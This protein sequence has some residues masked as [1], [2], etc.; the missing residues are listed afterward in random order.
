MNEEPVGKPRSIALLGMELSLGF[1]KGILLVV[2]LAL[3]FRM[4][5][6]QP[7]VVIGRSMEPNFH[8]RDYLVIDKLTYRF[9]APKRGEVIIFHPKPTPQ[10]S[11]IK[12]IV[13]LPGETVEVK[14]GKVFINDKSLSENYTLSDTSVPLNRDYPKTRLGTEEYFVFGDNRDHSSDSREI[15]AVPRVNIQGR[16][17]IVLLPIKNFKLPYVP[18]FGF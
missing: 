8:D 4:L 16:V 12:R 13:G 2:L 10:E 6:I 1:L 3:I 15:G 9:R 5:I 18:S 14:S 7:F 11:Y 17:A